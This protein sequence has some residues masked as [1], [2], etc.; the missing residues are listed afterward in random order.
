MLRV[1]EL[2]KEYRSSAGAVAA[3]TGMSFELGT[4]EVLSLVGPSG[5]GKTTILRCV[6]G[7]ETPDSGTITIGDTTMFSSAAGQNVPPHRRTIAMVFQ[8]YAIWPHMTVFDNVAYPLVTQRP[9]LA[10]QLIKDRVHESLEL[11]QI[12]AIAG[13]RA[14]QLSG[15]QQQRVAIARALVRHAPVLL[16]DEPL[17]NLDA[18]LRETTRGELRELFTKLGV[19]VLY[20]THDI[21]EALVI[22]DRLMVLAGGRLLEEGAPEE[23]YARPRSIL[24]AEFLGASQFA[25][26]TRSST[27]RAI[28]V[29]WLFGRHAVDR[30]DVLVDEIG[31]RVC[32]LARPTFVEVSA[33]QPGPTTNGMRPVEGTVESVLFLGSHVQYKV[34]AGADVVTAH[35]PP[36]EHRFLMGDTVYVRVDPRGIVVI[37]QPDPAGVPVSPAGTAPARA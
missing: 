7:L 34:R 5:C 33:A 21:G 6:A 36:H 37:P 1:A 16:L 26:V 29:E 4:S 12:R 3:V 22:S 20:V 31:A 13:R 15:G 32:I 2:T 17:S 25:G 18:Q 8:S 28:E 27:E 23:I 10:K 35:R 14:T 30:S 9:R 19:S 11:L 24:V